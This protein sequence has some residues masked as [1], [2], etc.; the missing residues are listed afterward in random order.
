MNDQ[1]NSLP[2]P[3]SR[4]MVE[5]LARVVGSDAGRLWLEPEQ[6]TGC[7]HCASAAACGMKNGHE[8]RLAA[9]RF[10]VADDGSLAVGD[11]VVI[12]IAEFTLLRASAIAYALPLVGMIGGALV[13]HAFGG[14]DAWAA[15]ATALGL[16]CGLLLARSRASRLRARGELTPRLLR[17]AGEGEVCPSEDGNQ[18]ELGH[19]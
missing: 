5:G 16:G 19:A 7:G 2:D 4:T 13:A 18:G 3:A 17:R 1:G 15:G 6:T 9:R 8:R 10:S 11:R 12:G 14:S